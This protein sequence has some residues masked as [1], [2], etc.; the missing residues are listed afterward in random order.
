MKSA[1]DTL[2]LSVVQ[3]SKVG[4]AGNFP[5][6]LSNGF[7]AVG[8]GWKY[9]LSVWMSPMKTLSALCSWY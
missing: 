9:G 7:G 8:C 3:S 4:S 1:H 6:E 2:Q 5:R